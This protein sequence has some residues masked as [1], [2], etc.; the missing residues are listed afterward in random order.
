LL[1]RPPPPRDWIDEA[2]LAR[3]PS[4]SIGGAL[5]IPSVDVP[6]SQQL[7]GRIESAK[8][9]GESV[10][11][12]KLAKAKAQASEYLGEKPGIRHL[13]KGRNALVDEADMLAA[14]RV[15]VK[16]G[17]EDSGPMTPDQAF[18]Q[19]VR[20]MNDYAQLPEW[21]KKG[22]GFFSYL[23]WR[24]K[25]VQSTGTAL[26]RK[27]TF[28]G[29]KVP[30][31]FSKAIEADPT[32]GKAQAALVGRGMMR[33]AVNASQWIAPLA[34]AQA[35]MLKRIGASK[36]DLDK[37]LDGKFDYLPESVR[38]LV[39]QTWIPT[40]KTELG[41]FVGVDASQ[42]FPELAVYRY[43][44]SNSRETPYGWQVLEK[45][46]T[47]GMLGEIVA[48]RDYQG[49][50]VDRGPKIPVIGLGAKQLL[51]P[52]A[53]RVVP[54]MREVE[55]WLAESDLPD[56]ERSAL[57][58]FARS[59]A[60]VPVQTIDEPNKNRDQIISWLD[61]GVLDIEERGDGSRNLYVRNPPSGASKALVQEYERARASIANP[62]FTNSSR[63]AIQ[64]YLRRKVERTQERM[65]Q[66]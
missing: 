24:A 51:K 21:V 57:R 10:F 58:F 19:V 36:D 12:L 65:G 56:N 52:I 55:A 38:W 37:Y 66:R 13:K 63:F 4:A 25:V 29:V 27:P 59:I 45:S 61:R 41:R 3:L 6:R 30:E 60:G 43:L 53:E 34:G 5:D 31:P 42:V 62:M 28:Y 54:G 23:R 20:P 46:I 22:S 18:E 15:A 33:L 16:Q 40:A 50:N 2:F 39:K 64:Q 9:T 49:H 32:S 48:G 1:W 17:I 7:A 11:P 47:G 44:A 14:F 26:E 35:A 8:R